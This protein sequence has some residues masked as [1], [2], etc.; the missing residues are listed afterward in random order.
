MFAFLSYD[1]VIASTSHYEMKTFMSHYYFPFYSVSFEFF[2]DRIPHE[3]EELDSKNGNM[4]DH[5]PASATI[6]RYSCLLT[7]QSW[8]QGR[9]RPSLTKQL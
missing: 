4:F 2:V 3:I 1:L 8:S 6:G 5:H 7:E 9:D